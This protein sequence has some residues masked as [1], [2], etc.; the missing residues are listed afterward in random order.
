MDHTGH[1]VAVPVASAGDQQAEVVREVLDASPEIGGVPWVPRLDGVEAVR[2]KPPE[3]PAGRPVLEMGGGHHA[4]EAVNQVGDLR[5]RWQ[6]FRLEG[7]PAEPQVPVE[8]HPHIR[9]RA[10]LHQGPGDVGAP[11]GSRRPTRSRRRHHV[12]DADGDV[13]SPEASHHGLGPAESVG[14]PVGQ[15]PIDDGLVQGEK[16]PQQVHL[17]PRC[18]NGELAPRDDPEAQTITLFPGTGKAGN[19]VVVGKGNGFQPF[20]LG[21]PHHLVG[22]ELA[23]RGRGV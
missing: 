22:R 1:G 2:L 12:F 11:D 16:I 21:P 17:S 4:T 15:V 9:Y 13:Q 10:P 23:I 14:A 18:G 19:G 20:G 5:Q 6:A 8:G 7:G 3:I